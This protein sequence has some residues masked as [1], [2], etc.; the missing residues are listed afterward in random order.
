MAVDWKTG[1][2]RWYYQTLKHDIWDLD[3]PETPSVFNVPINGTMTPV[4]TEGCKSGIFVALNARN[5]SYLPHFNFQKIQTY[6]P[7]GRGEKLNGLSSTQWIPQGAAGC[8]APEDLTAAGISKCAAVVAGSLVP[9]SAKDGVGSLSTGTA[10]LFP[11]DFMQ[12]SYGGPAPHPGVPGSYGPNVSGQNGTDPCPSCSIVNVAD[13]RPVV[14]TTLAA[15][16]TSDAYFAFGGTAQGPFNYPHKAY[17]PL[18]HDQYACVR[19]SASGKSNTGSFANGTES[20]NSATLGGAVADP[21]LFTASVEALNLTNNTFSWQYGSKVDTLGS[22]NAGTIATAGNLVF[23]GFI[24]RTDQTATQLFYAGLPPGGT[25]AAFDATNGNLLWQWGTLGATFA[26]APITYTY[27]GKQYIA[28]YHSMPTA[29]A[30]PGGV[31]HLPSD[32]R[33]ELTVFSL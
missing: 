1:A 28:I 7:T 17:S 30:L 21:R 19:S 2:L 11:A 4:V 22:C 13:N 20:T 16:H 3:C 32:Q 24:G 26:S 12:I 6:D 5:G 23:T 25:L 27:Q 29:T 18:T 9:A 10:S 33:E 8:V 31:G 14:G 15:A